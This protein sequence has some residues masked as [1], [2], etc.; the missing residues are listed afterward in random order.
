MASDPRDFLLPDLGEGLEDAVLVEWHVQEGDVVT[1]NQTLCTVETAK[2]T[3]DIPSPFAGTVMQ[4]V[5]D[6]GATIDVGSLLVRIAPGDAAGAAATPSPPPAVE[7]AAAGAGARTRT[8]TLVG[9]GPDEGPTRRRRRGRA[10]APPPPPPTAA[11]PPPP[12]PELVVVPSG[13]VKALAKPPVRKLARELGV[14]LAS[15]AP[16][17]GPHGSVTRDDVRRAA[18]APMSAAPVQATAVARPSLISTSPDVRMGSVIP[19]Q[20]IRARIAERMTQ[21]RSIIPDASCAVTVDCGRLL[22]LRTQLRE[23][24]ADR[25][26]ADVL[27]P[28]VLI[29]R[30]LIAA[31]RSR[32]I[33][34]STFDAEHGEIRVHE[35]IHLGIG[36]DTPRGLMV[37]VVRHA[38]QLST[39][40]LAMEV[41]RLAD[42]ARA[43]TLAPN[44]LVGSTFTVSNF[45][46]FGIDDGYPVINY[47][48]VAI[49]GV[50]AIRERPAVVDGEIVARP[51]A[52]FTCSF[53]HR[54]CDGSDAG[55]FL[56]RLRELVEQ[57]EQLILES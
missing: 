19:V 44:D 38:D 14:D 11:P 32:P 40:D 13:N 21:S 52:N 57:P 17:S 8:P 53:D 20:G 6:P 5:G 54:V 46:V 45:G 25:L 43:G 12:P 10:A 55:A 28:F 2:A 34:N 51:I 47:P 36:A 48:E 29:L 42:G 35:A 33:L 1:L 18:A 9:Y 24:T 39:M 4:R 16:G 27:T 15:L 3:V 7:P 23:T 41:R 26:D 50:G 49:L 22:E 56:G 37:P 31:L 30:L